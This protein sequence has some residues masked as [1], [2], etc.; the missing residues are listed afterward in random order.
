MANA[1]HQRGLTLIE[2]MVAMA[3]S[4]VLAIAAISALTISRQGFTTV[5][6]ASQLRDNARF[7]TDLVQRLG[8]QSGFK[9]VAF[10]GTVRVTNVAGTSN[11]PEPSV[12]GY[13]N[14]Y[15]SATAIANGTDPLASVNGS[16]PVGKS[17]ILVLRYQP[18]ETFPGSGVTDKTMID[19]NGAPSAAPPAGRD[20]RLVSV[21]HVANDASGEP[22]LMCT[23]LVPTTTSTYTTTALVRGVDTFQVLYGGDGVTAGGDSAMLP[24]NG[25]GDLLPKIFLRADQLTGSTPVYTNNN[26][27]RIRAIRVG[28]ILRGDNGSAQTTSSG[29][30]YP[31]GPGASASGGAVGSALSSASD[32]GTVFSPSPADRRL[33]QTVTFTVHLRNDQAY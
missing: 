10:A 18:A 26:W 6:A 4:L 32:L 2:L 9:D 7:V 20:D 33:R 28:L 14:S 30:F 5:D 15:I 13:N 8:V 1:G 12:F 23:T 21:L 19:C 11:N 22:S 29:P 3:I 24:W 16:N 31:L 27:R 25:G 17:D